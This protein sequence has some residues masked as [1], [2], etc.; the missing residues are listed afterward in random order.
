MVRLGIK[1]V[2]GHGAGKE[3]LGF[4]GAALIGAHLAQPDERCVVVRAQLNGPGKVSTRCGVLALLVLDLPQPEVRVA[5]R[6]VDL[7]G[8]GKGRAGRAVLRLALVDHAEVVENGCVVRG[9]CLRLLEDCDRFGVAAI[10]C[11]GDG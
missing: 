9:Q 1:R 7:G 2:E 8:A 10:V 4:I 5:I 11:V 3:P 6:G